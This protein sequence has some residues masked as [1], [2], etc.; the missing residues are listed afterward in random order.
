MKAEVIQMRR[1]LFFLLFA[2]LAFLPLAA[3]AAEAPGVR[4]EDFS[5]RGAALG[6]TEEK[7]L[8]VYG[9]PLFDTDTMKDGVA[10]RVYTFRGGIDVGVEKKTGRV[11]DFDVRSEDFS[12]R[13]VKKGAT[14]YWIQ[15]TFGKVSRTNLDGQTA[16]IYRRA[17]T[18][19]DRASLVLIVDP[20][21]R[22]LTSLRLTALPLTEEERHEAVSEGDAE[23]AGDIDTSRLPTAEEPKLGGLF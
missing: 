14:L 15:K 18:E 8:S 19:E 2:L 7:L 23:M 11:V 13:G 6:D 16:Y 5:Y 20:E 1:G 9:E 4:A 21:T 17:R 12:V 22:V 10:L 3:Y